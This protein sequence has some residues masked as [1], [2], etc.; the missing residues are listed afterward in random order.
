MGRPPRIYRHV[1]PDMWLSADFRRLS[2]DAK[3]LWTYLLSS[4]RGCA[5][6]GAVIATARVMASDLD[7]TDRAFAKA[8]AELVDFG[9]VETDD[10]AG[11]AVLTKALIADGHARESNA[12][13]TIKSVVTWVR[14]LSRLPICP[15]RDAVAARL[16]MFFSQ[17]GGQFPKAFADAMADSCT[18][19]VAHRVP[20][21][22]H[23]GAGIR[24]QGSSF[25]PAGARVVPAEQPAPVPAIGTASALPPVAPQPFA[26]MVKYLT[27]AVEMLNAA[28][29][30]IDPNARPIAADM[31]DEMALAAHMRPIPEA[32][33]EAAI[34]HGVAV[35]AEAVK[36]GR[37]TMDALRIGELAGP[38]SWR[39]WQ[40]ATVHS[41]RASVSGRDGPG[42]RRFANDRQIAPMPS[43]PSAAETRRKLD[44][45]RER[46]RQAKSEAVGVSEALAELKQKLGIQP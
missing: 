27:L 40:A 28:R 10:R 29:A 7:W 23:Q 4:P 39:K 6:P 5:I 11:L 1:E 31:G 15:L 42:G 26:P 17:L 19:L 46:D 2:R 37:V 34:R 12:P 16:A 35:I 21:L 24:E 36:A 45:Q 30:S 3:A 32:D 22:V 33:R 9:M 18:S 14:A 41:I 25:S 13:S 8:M 43:A 44:E 38:K 20:A